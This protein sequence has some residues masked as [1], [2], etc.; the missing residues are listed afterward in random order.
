MGGGPSLSAPV[1]L[2][3]GCSLQNFPEPLPWD[4]SWRISPFPLSVPLGPVQASSAASTRQEM[5]PPR[6]G[7][8]VQLPVRLLRSQPLGKG[9]EGDEGVHTR[10]LRDI[11]IDPQIADQSLPDIKEL[12]RISDPN[13]SQIRVPPTHQ[14]HM[15]NESLENCFSAEGWLGRCILA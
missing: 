10:L 13:S 8:K 5:G 2:P 6:R 7:N 9:R 12:P 1:T 14:D 3:A 4:L 15:A 11:G